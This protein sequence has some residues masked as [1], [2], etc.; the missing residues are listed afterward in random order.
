MHPEEMIL[1][2]QDLGEVRFRLLERGRWILEHEGV[3]KTNGDIAGVAENYGVTVEGAV[4]RYWAWLT[5]NSAN[6]WIITLR[7]NFVW[8]GHTWRAVNPAIYEQ[9]A[10][11]M[12]S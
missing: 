9:L 1:A 5:R 10:Q 11:R 8:G 2:L 7:G 4:T 12:A 3:K 6:S